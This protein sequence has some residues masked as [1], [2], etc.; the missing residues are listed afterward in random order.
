MI[1]ALIGTEGVVYAFSC[2]AESGSELGK[3]YG[4]HWSKVH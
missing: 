1:L 2:S 3:F 4:I